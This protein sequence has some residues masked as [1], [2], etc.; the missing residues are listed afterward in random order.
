MNG[1]AL[2]C[3]NCGTIIK[4]PAATTCS[5][6]CAPLPQPTARTAAQL[7]GELEGGWDDLDNE[8]HGRDDPLPPPSAR[9]PAR[10]L[11]GL[12]GPK[13]TGLDAPSTGPE[14]LVGVTQPMPILCDEPSEPPREPPLAPTRLAEP[15]SLALPDDVPAGLPTMPIERVPLSPDP[16][17]RLPP[18]LATA[19]RRR[20]G[21][22]IG[23][24]T[25]PPMGSASVGK[26]LPTMNVPQPALSDL[27]D[28]E[29]AIEA[30]Q[31]SDGPHGI[32]SSFG[33]AAFD[34]IS[35]RANDD[36]D[37]SSVE[38]SREA[39][40]IPPLS[41][42]DVTLPPL[43]SSGTGDGQPRSVGVA[44]GSGETPL[45][46]DPATN[47]P[48]AVFAPAAPELT[49]SAV[50]ETQPLAF[51]ED[52]TLDLPAPASS[53]QRVSVGLIALWIVAIASLVAATLVV[54]LR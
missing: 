3:G 30:T 15:V 11:V 12:G 1:K 50:V 14:G 37:A 39:K 25:L 49:N 53:P 9:E 44:T 32:E 31:R 24:T 17:E 54:V 52:K 51:M 48:G 13:I 23:S 16:Q 6:C 18:A 5:R 26:G 41:A 38:R 21:P 46:P 45:E 47:R 35:M 10:T 29:L 36:L 27:S 20:R 19:S 22:G 33:M 7:Q 28:A 2:Q 34:E 42:G 40:A 43:T 8:V 4:D